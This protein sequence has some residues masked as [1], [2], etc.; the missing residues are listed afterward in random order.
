MRDQV[1]PEEFPYIP[2]LNTH[3]APCMT[4]ISD[5]CKDLNFISTFLAQVQLP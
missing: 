5:H 4:I 3:Q 2:Y 1:T